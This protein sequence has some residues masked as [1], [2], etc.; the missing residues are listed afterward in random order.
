MNNILIQF[1]EDNDVATEKQSNSSYREI[2]QQES[3]YF[4]KTVDRF[5]IFF[6][7][8]IYTLFSSIKFALPYN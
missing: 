5:V 4:E 2:V 7:I 1:T 3:Q 8:Y 6:V